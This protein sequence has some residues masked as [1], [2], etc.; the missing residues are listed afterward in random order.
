[1][2]PLPLVDRL[3]LAA[4]LAH[5]WLECPGYCSLQLRIS[6]RKK[7]RWLMC[8]FLLQCTGN[9]TERSGWHLAESL[10]LE[11]LYYFGPLPPVEL[12]SPEWWGGVTQLALGASARCPPPTPLPSHLAVSNLAPF[13]FDW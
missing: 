7:S 13:L 10:S 9:I 4:L 8:S 11:G 2:E 1:M 12:A 3:L 5:S 6:L